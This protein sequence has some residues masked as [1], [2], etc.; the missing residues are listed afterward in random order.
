MQAIFRDRGGRSPAKKNPGG[1]FLK[2]RRLLL[3]L[4]VL[5]AVALCGFKLL[6]LVGGRSGLIGLGTSLL[7]WVRNLGAWS[8]PV[9]FATEAV[10]FLLLL[11]SY[12]C[13]PVASAPTNVTPS[14]QAD[15]Y[16]LSYMESDPESHPMS[17]VGY[18][19]EQGPIHMDPWGRLVN[20]AA[21]SHASR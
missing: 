13:G 17:D 16:S 1:Q 9:L 10:C 21:P 12:E 15:E 19:A 5:L 8:V 2:W 20:S 11:C 6:Q 3:A 14:P 4:V 18:I 7:D